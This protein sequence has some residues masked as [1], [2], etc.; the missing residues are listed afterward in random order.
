MVAWYI[1]VLV[2]ICITV[3]EVHGSSPTIGPAYN[4]GISDKPSTPLPDSESV[5]VQVSEASIKAE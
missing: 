3:R 5:R 1:T 2:A 4:H